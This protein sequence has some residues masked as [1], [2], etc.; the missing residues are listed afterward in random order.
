[1]RSA[2]ACLG[3]KKQQRILLRL[4]AEIEKKDQGTEEE[5]GEGDG[6]RP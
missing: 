1:M 3:A 6:E 4:E 2:T 5:L